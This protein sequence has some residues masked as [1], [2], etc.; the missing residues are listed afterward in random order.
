[1]VT[2]LSDQPQAILLRRRPISLNNLSSKDVVF[3]AI[4]KKGGQANN[5]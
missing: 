2:A 5:D 4:K 1:L 3:G